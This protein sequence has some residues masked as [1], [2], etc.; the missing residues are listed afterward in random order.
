MPSLVGSEM[1][2]RD[3]DNTT[4][5]PPTRAIFRS[6]RSPHQGG[7]TQ[8]PKFWRLEDIVEILTQTHEPLG[9]EKQRMFEGVISFASY[10]GLL[11]CG[12]QQNDQARSYPCVHREEDLDLS[13]VQAQTNA[14]R[15]PYHQG[16]SDLPNYFWARKHMNISM[17][18]T[19]SP[20]PVSYTHLTLPTIYSV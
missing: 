16:A 20:T 1:C 14:A 4:L 11:L 13:A 8:K 19:N 10:L 2:I 5:P 7:H 6:R 3:S 9:R 18:P 15:E 17:K 12:D